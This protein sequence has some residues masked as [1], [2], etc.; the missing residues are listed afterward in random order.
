MATMLN[1]LAIVDPRHASLQLWQNGNKVSAVS[2]W[3]IER[4]ISGSEALRHMRA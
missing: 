1:H 2:R 4:E 3:S